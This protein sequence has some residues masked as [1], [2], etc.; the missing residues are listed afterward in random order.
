MKK[1]Y[2]SLAICGLLFNSCDKYLEED[3]RS[4]VVAEEFYVSEDGYEALVNAN[5]ALLSDI[6]GG[7]PWVFC[8]GTDMYSE[9]RN[10]QPIE[11]SEYANLSPSTDEI[12]DLYINAYNAIQKANMGLY[13][14]DVTEQ[15]DNINSRK[16]ELK[17]LRANAYFLLVQSYGGVG[18]IT[19]YISSPILSFD[20]NSEEE[21]Y[22][23]I[24]SE[25]TE[26]INLVEDGAYNG[27][28]NKRA[29]QHLLA[30]VYLTRGYLSFGSSDDF[31][32]AATLADAAI[33][34]QAL[35]IPFNDLWQPG[36]EM[37]AETL[38]SVQYSE[39]ITAA[40]PTGLGNLQSYYFGSYLGGAE[41]AGDAPNRSYNLIA[42]DYA[43]DLFTEKDARWE[44][45]FMIEIFDRY[46]DYYDKKDHSGLEVVDYYAPSWKSTTQDS[47]DYKAA[48]P[49]ATFHSYGTY[50]AS[51]VSGD[52]ALITAKKFDDPDEPFSNG[53][54]STRDI[55]L[56]RLGE[57]YLIAAEA[58]FKA[59][60]S[61]TAL[62]RL[63][64][65]RSRAGVDP[66]TTIDIDVIL[67]ERGR[68]LFGEYHRWFDLK[69]T[70]T[71]VERASMYNYLV[72]EENFAG[73]NGELKILRPI[74][75]IA[76]DLNQNNDFTQNPAYD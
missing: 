50:S 64:E 14:A 39:A 16:G 5:Y 71:L 20:R 42:T 21:V 19:D 23:F 62:E 11:I 17:Y 27:R 1:I 31:N 45:T 66:M 53:R 22:S 41:V 40:D 68:E 43:I 3:V 10:P 37:N 72:N 47:L 48:H 55:I 33:N 9:G 7:E 69:R 38:F 63:N 52:R 57:T 25:L 44:G 49:K 32:Q 76:I 59:G 4:N 67:D 61:G 34:G 8:A 46:Y 2:I 6:Y 13:Y 65:V 15:T 29:V 24:I 51:I 73:N 26:A 30:K 56:S 60:N 58:Y 74:P 18:L 75:Q 28:V 12:E 54:S 70:G 36:N 35:S